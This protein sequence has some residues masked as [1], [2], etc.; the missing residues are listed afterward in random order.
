MSDVRTISQIP[1]LDALFE[2]SRDK[3]VFLLKH[4]LTC[5]ISSRARQEY[6]RFV[7]GRS[8]DEAV[9]LLLEVQNARP[10]SNEVAERTGIRHESPQALLV[11][12]GRVV[13]H[14]SHFQI[15]GDALERALAA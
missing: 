14:A 3:P 10:L 8:D 11:R 4:S 15:R 1:E 12:D 13:W 5:P 2:R 9:F 6:G 7:A